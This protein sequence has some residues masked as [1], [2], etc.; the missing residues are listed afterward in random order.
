LF[1]LKDGKEIEL[2]KGITGDIG[3]YANYLPQWIR[4]RWN[5]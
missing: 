3:Y 5:S 4:V 2:V 1:L